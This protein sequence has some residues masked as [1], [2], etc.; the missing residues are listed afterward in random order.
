MK[1]PKLKVGVVGLGYMGIHH[2]RVLKENPD[3]ELVA[4]SDTNEIS[5]YK[6][7]ERFGVTGYTDYKKLIG[8]VDAVN[9][10]VPTT[11]HYEIAKSFLINGIHVLLEKPITRTL[12]EAK[13]LNHLAKSSGVVLQVG[14]TE[15]F[16]PAVMAV[17][18]LVSKPLFIEANRMGPSTFR[19]MDIGVVLELMIH[20]IDILLDLTKSPIKKI[21]ALG[22]S[23]YS[24]FED[25]AIV[26]ILFESGCLA[27]LVASRITVEKIR[28]LEI[29]L[30]DTFISVDYLDQNISLRKQFSSGY[31]FEEG[32]PH[33]RK[34]F[35]VEKPFVGKEEPLKL[36]IQHFIDCILKGKQ[37]IISGEEALRSLSVAEQILLNMEILESSQKEELLKQCKNG[38]V[39]KLF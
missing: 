6:A 19:N 22:A 1:L 9:V 16:N 20:D 7:T 13:A 17:K 30:E 8:M 25:I 33:Y 21:Q 39:L 34:E 36:E 35:L 32:R 2:A 37:P 12:E 10:V 3:V 11:L 18:N 31:V 15:R 38:K 14:H 28:K 27:S 23:V 5:L 26:Q 4:L 24:P 29:T